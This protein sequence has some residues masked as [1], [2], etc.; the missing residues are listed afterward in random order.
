MAKSVPEIKFESTFEQH[1]NDGQRSQEIC[2]SG[3]FLWMKEPESRSKQNAKSH[4]QN[5]IGNARD[6]ENAISEE[7]DNQEST[8]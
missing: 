8:D 2:S 3:K 5:N 4:Q 7:G 6:F 1:Q